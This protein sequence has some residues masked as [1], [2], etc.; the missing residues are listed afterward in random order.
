MRVLMFVSVVCFVIALLGQVDAIH[1]VNVL[2]WAL[3]GW[4]AW[5]VDIAIG[6]YVLPAARS[7]PR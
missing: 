6:G 3:A 4:L 5:A 7:R 2:A 1:G